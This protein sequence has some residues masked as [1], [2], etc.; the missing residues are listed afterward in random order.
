MK[1]PQILFSV[2][3]LVLL[4]LS[5]HY[6]T[7]SSEHNIVVPLKEEGCAVT[8]VIYEGMKVNTL[9]NVLDIYNLEEGDTIHTKEDMNVIL[10]ATIIEMLKN[11]DDERK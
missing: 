11:E 1:I 4:I 3:M 5:I 6:G 2:V 8:Y 7:K 9:N 10:G